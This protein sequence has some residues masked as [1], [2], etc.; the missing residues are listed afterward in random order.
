MDI[1]KQTGN[2]MAQI[3]ENLAA[4][5]MLALALTAHAVTTGAIIAS[6]GQRI[7]AL[8]QASAQDREER[9]EVRNLLRSLSEQQSA[10]IAE[11]RVLHGYQYN[12]QPMNIKGQRK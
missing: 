5:A 3:K 4:W 8:E 6:Q 9:R 11:Q 1:A 10:M 7:T 2:L 12:E